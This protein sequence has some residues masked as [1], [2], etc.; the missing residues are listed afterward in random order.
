MTIVLMHGFGA[1][2]HLLADV[3]IK[4]LVSRLG[5]DGWL[6]HAPMVNPYNTVP[7]RARQWMKHLTELGVGSGTRLH[8]IGFSSGG[9]DARF[10]ISRMGGHEFVDS[11]TT[12]STP[13]L[14]SSLAAY[15]LD[16]PATLQAGIAKVADWMG[17]RL[18]GKAVSNSRKA[19]EQLTPS[20]MNDEF[21]PA[22]PD[23]PD[24]T[25]RSWAGRAGIGTDTPIIPLLRVT[26]RIIYNRE[27]VNDG[28]VSVECA[29]WAGFQGTVEADHARQI[30]V[31]MLNGTFDAP[32]F[33]SSILAELGEVRSA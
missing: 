23:H 28:I 5:S 15:L 19:L 30:G 1:F 25:Y 17:D 18:L 22:T 9:L 32:E 16:S 29:K 3:S 11:L 33:V 8:L 12:I 4:P 31:R 2:M 7:E 27:G 13:H 21:N 26:N 10:L 6:V 14:G 24:V 20:Y